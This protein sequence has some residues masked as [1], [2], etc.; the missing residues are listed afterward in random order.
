L[1]EVATRPTPNKFLNPLPWANRPNPAPA[2]ASSAAW[3]TSSTPQRAVVR[4]ARR[5]RTCWTKAS[6][7]SKKR[8][9]AKAPRTTSLPWSRPRTSKSPTTSVASTGAPLAVICLSRTSQPG[10]V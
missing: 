1:P 9:W 5:T 3:A 6:T 2:A 10:S 8:S 7:C 4:K